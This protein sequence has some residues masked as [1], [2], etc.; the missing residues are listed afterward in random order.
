MVSRCDPVHTALRLS[1]VPI[2]GLYRF[3]LLSFCFNMFGLRKGARNT[4]VRGYERRY[5]TRPRTFSRKALGCYFCWCEGGFFTYSFDFEKT[6]KQTKVTFVVTRGFRKVVLACLCPNPD[7]RIDIE[8]FMRH[9]WVSGVDVPVCVGLQLSSIFFL[10][11]TL[12]TGHTAGNS[13]RNDDVKWD[14]RSR[15]ARARRD[16]DFDAPGLS[17]DL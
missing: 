9:R 13:R 5:Q 2:K 8:G 14:P 12:N 10:R 7:K 4:V 1:A 17:C 16:F 3:R 6:N 11:S 15:L